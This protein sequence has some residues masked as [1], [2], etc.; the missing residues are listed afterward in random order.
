MDHSRI[1]E[2]INEEIEAFLSERCH[3][4]TTGYFEKCK[5]GSSVYSQT[6]GSSR[7]SDRYAGRGIYQGDEADGTP[8]LRAKYGVNGSADVSAGRVLF[9]DGTPIP[10][11]YSVSKYKQK[12]KRANEHQGGELGDGFNDLIA[13]LQ[14]LSSK[15]PDLLESPALQAWL[16]AQD[17]ELS[18]IKEK[19][20]KKNTCSCRNERA[21]AYQNGLNAA[22]T[23]IKAYESSKKGE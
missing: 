4:P 21:K 22:L 1:E 17:Y 15:K 9:D 6:K 18:E 20:G 23:F 10:P 3:S 19:I 5:K 2:I 7:Y 14:S 13:F 16:K 12:Y 11:T 8:K